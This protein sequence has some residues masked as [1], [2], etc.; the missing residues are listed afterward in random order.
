MLNSPDR[1]TPRS[2]EPSRAEMHVA[3]SWRIPTAQNGRENSDCWSWMHATW[4]LQDFAIHGLLLPLL[5]WIGNGLFLLMA[6]LFFELAWFW[7][8]LHVACLVLSIS[9]GLLCMFFT[10]LCCYFQCFHHL[11]LFVC[12]GLSISSFLILRWPRN[13]SWRET[14]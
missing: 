10:A 4:S 2:M 7:L 9:F 1:C 14:F 13:V 12:H 6:L 11:S 3:E 5:S 8:R